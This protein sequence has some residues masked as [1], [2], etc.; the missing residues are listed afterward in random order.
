VFF[1]FFKVETYHI[2]NWC[3]LR[4]LKS[5]QKFTFLKIVP[6]YLDTLSL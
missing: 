6:K 3:K 2:I 4:K 5:E 1:F